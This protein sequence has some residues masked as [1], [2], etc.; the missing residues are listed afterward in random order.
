MFELAWTEVRQV[1][2]DGLQDLVQLVQTSVWPIL[3]MGH[4]S[5][6]SYRPTTN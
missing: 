3:N 5:Y 4:T 6:Y 2:H 1:W